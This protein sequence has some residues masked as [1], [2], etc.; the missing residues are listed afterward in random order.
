M[1]PIL[2]KWSLPIPIVLLSLCSPMVLGQQSAEP[3]RTQIG[4]IQRNDSNSV[5]AHQQ[6]IEKT[7]Q[8]KIDVYFV[9]D[10]ITRRWGATDYPA[11][12]ANWKKNF[13]GWNAANFGWG[14]DTTN[15]IL[16]R[17]ENGE[18]D[19]VA[20]KVFVVQAGTNNL[21]WSGPTDDSKVDEVVASI[22]SLLALLQKRS[23]SSK[24]VLTALFPRSQNP[25]LSPSIQRINK[26]LEE[27]TDGK[28]IRF[29]N[30]NVKLADSNGV[31]LPGMSDDGLHFTEK[32]YQVWADALN[33]ILQELLGLPGAEDI[34]PPPTGDPNAQKQQTPK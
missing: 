10:S 15:N 1:L 9:G 25:A 6:L 11:F 29:V 8:G 33:P 3:T 4:S 24:I 23:P 20:P 2:L 18:L 30:I 7:K 27:L 12:L 13:Y 5:M 14:G 32:S 28:Q 16:W 26:Q 34:A 31:L 21:P 17:M 19:G 22:K